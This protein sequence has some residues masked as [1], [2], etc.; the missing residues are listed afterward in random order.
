MKLECVFCGG[1]KGLS[2]VWSVAFG[3]SSHKAEQVIVCAGCERVCGVC[4]QAFVMDEVHK[5]ICDRCRI[6][7]HIENDRYVRIPHFRAELARW[8][9]TER[10]VALEGA[11][12]LEELKRSERELVKS[13]GGA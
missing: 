5:G 3:E 4:D 8:D 6:L 11:R 2:I 1:H 13:Q 10:G 12:L 9:G 7:E